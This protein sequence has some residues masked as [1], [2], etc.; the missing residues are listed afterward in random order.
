VCRRS[1]RE[2]TSSRNPSAGTTVRNALEVVLGI[3]TDIMSTF[4]NRLTKAPVDDQLA[5]FAA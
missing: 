1:D 2:P 4:A 3:G 5:A